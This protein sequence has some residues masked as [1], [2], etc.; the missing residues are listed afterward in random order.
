MISQLGEQ[1][2]ASSTAGAEVVQQ[3]EA[4][5]AA[6]RA[7]RLEAE[8][9]LAA[10]ATDLAEA[11]RECK[12]LNDQVRPALQRH[13]ARTPYK[14]VVVCRHTLLLLPR[15]CILGV[16]KQPYLYFTFLVQ[17]SQQSGQL[18][19]QVAALAEV[20]A[21]SASLRDAAAKAATYQDQLKEADRHIDSLKARI[22][23]LQDQA[24]AEDDEQ[25]CAHQIHR[26][27]SYS[28]NSYIPRS[29]LFFISCPSICP[30]FSTRCNEQQKT[31][32]RFPPSPLWMC[33]VHKYP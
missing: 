25:R 3:L 16:I 5:L 29:F 15:A 18:Q 17:V 7:E 19:Q 8:K 31:R 2:G 13:V 12:A 30:I 27:A 14:F 6:A 21:D 24:Q 10:V 11:V 9:K 4:D 26:Q 1:A 20:R 33:Y 22:Q 32:C 28:M 23:Q